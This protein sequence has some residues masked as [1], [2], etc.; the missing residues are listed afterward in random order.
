LRLTVVGGSVA[1]SSPGAAATTAGMA[2]TARM[3]VA[4]RPNSDC[5][6]WQARAGRAVISVR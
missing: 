2:S 5:G 3:A 6:S 1:E 4:I